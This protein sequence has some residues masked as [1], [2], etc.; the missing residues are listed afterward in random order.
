MTSSSSRASGERD[1]GPNVSFPPPLLYVAGFGLGALIE[2]FR[3]PP[4]RLPDSML[5]AVLGAIMFVGGL[6]L[7]AT[8]ILTF[9]RHRTAVYPNR[10]ARNLVTSG[11]Y[12][13]TRNPMYVGLAAAYLGGVVMTALFWPLLLLPFVLALTFA[14]VIRREEQHL[15]EKFPDE[16][17]DY[18]ARVRRWL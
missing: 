8:G 17:L 16:Y 12:A 6:A 7:V 3:P 9:R 14:L 2:R 18:T 5:T 4:V 15:L 13:R 10:P 11:V 1:R